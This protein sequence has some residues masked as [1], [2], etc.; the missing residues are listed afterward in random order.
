MKAL[1][2]VL[3]GL[4]VAALAAAAPAV[5]WTKKV[6]QTPAGAFVLGNPAAK[7]HLVEYVSYTCPHCAHFT[8][9][10]NAALRGKYIATGGTA[11]EIRHAVRDPL[12]LAATLIARCAGPAHFFATHEKL[13]ATQEQWFEKGVQYWQANTAALQAASPKE[14]GRAHV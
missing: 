2:P 3:A 14:I 9:E 4:A 13:F 6:T 11:V 10:S 1:K 12:D 8:N 5:D 7:T